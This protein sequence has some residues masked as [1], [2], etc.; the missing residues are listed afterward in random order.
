MKGGAVSVEGGRRVLFRTEPLD[1]ESPRGYL[2]RVAEAMELAG[3]DALLKSL[4]FPDSVTVDTEGLPKVAHAL[5]LDPEEFHGF[6]YSARRHFNDRMERLFLGQKIG[7]TYLNF[8]TPRVCPKCIGEFGSL[9]AVWD[10]A[11]VT[12][13]PLHG[14]CLVDRCPV[15]KRTLSPTRPRIGQC[16][17]GCD[18]SCLASEVASPQELALVAAI[19]RAAGQPYGSEGVIGKCGLPE[20]FLGLKLQDTLR[21]VSFLGASFC[22][23]GQRLSQATWRRSVIEDAR[24]VLSAAGT[25]MMQWPEGIGNALRLVASQYASERPQDRKFAKMFWSYYSFLFKKLGEPQFE[26]LHEAFDD[27]VRDGWDAPLRQRD[28]WLGQ[29]LK[30]DSKWMTPEELAGMAERTEARQ[31]REYVKNG[32]LKGTI[33]SPGVGGVSYVWVEREDALAWLADKSNWLP[34]DEVASL[35]GVHYLIVMQLGTVGVLRARKGGVAGHS[36]SWNFS[37]SDVEVVLQAFGNAGQK[38]VEVGDGLVTLGDRVLP[39]M[40]REK[41]AYGLIFKAVIGGDLVPVGRAGKSLG[42]LDFVFKKAQIRACLLGGCREHKELVSLR[43]AGTVLG[44]NSGTVGALVKSGLLQT[45]TRPSP[46]KETFVSMDTVMEFRGRYV[47]SH[48]LGK[49][50]NTNGAW[51]RRYLDSIGVGGVSVDVWG[52]WN[53]YV[54][55]RESVA[56]IV[57][58]PSKHRRP[59]GALLC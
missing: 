32:V 59:K 13:C 41:G 34:R 55:L 45:A 22:N 49:K 43:E 44:V 35:L 14:C 5:R 9:P 24:M 2:L 20:G 51:A 40:F 4:G 50:C 7:L 28:R 11:L 29:R 47:F 12:A 19:H 30:S 10:L 15:C 6:F 31:I 26:F 48:E 23:T 27:F 8:S 17:C 58:P 38:V 21:V 16:R 54:Y 53:C 56:D 36:R 46:G 25:T 33:S 42:V 37:R 39:P 3:A 57:I 1:G 18:L 52:K